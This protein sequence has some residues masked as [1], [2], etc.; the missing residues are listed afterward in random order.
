MPVL[1][2]VDSFLRVDTRTLPAG[3]EEFIKGALT[4]PNPEFEDAK[5]EHVRGWR[6]MPETLKLYGYQGTD[7]ILP[8]GFAVKFK[9]G[10]RRMGQE[11]V[12]D[13]RRVVTPAPSLEG[14]APIMLRR[15]QRPAV[16]RIIQVQQGIY[17]AP[18]GSGKTVTVLE[19]FRW[20]KTRSL[21]IVD[22]TNIARQWQ[23]RAKAFL[24]Y[25]IGI[26]GDGEWDEK[27]ITVALVQTLSSRRNE[28]D[29]SW[30][31]S[32]GAVCLDECHHAPATTFRMAMESFPAKWRFG[33]SATPDRE[34]GTYPL[35]LAALGEVFHTTGK[36]ELVDE[37]ILVRPK[38]HVI[39]TDFRFDF[40]RTQVEGGRVR[41]NNYAQMMTALVD[42]DERNMLIAGAVL[43]GRGH[44]NLVISKRLGHLDAI[45]EIVVKGGWPEHRALM[46]TGRED[47][48]ERMRVSALA[49]E[50]DVVIFST[51]ADEALDIPRLDRLYLAWPTR[52]A[53]I[54]RQQ[55]GRVERAHHS[56]EGAVVFDFLDWHVRVLR[57]QFGNRRRSVYAPEN[58]PIEDLA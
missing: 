56:K 55:V 54:I 5:R 43:Q 49:A 44:A 23:E 3:A 32:W 36:D 8:R 31:A 57:G 2:T 58:L 9:N 6:S 27:D 15:H 50:A 45:R 39:K 22:K 52:N 47:S 13:D 35:A 17:M 51:I 33:V 11:V 18:P 12:Y 29:V 28:L 40:V 21:V 26:I 16:D 4:I 38:V 30:W 1:A 24:N 42:D 37:G 14:L 20:L 10:M 25:D 34:N 41:R 19:T 48:V 46:L 53:S 7:I